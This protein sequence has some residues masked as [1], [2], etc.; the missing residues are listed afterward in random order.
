M[1]LAPC[2][3]VS[4]VYIF[5][6]YIFMLI[7]GGQRALHGCYCCLSG[8][9]YVYYYIVIAWLAH[10]H[11]HGHCMRS[12]AIC[13]Y[14]YGCCQLLLTSCSPRGSFI[15]LAAVLETGREDLRSVCR[16]VFVCLLVPGIYLVRGYTEAW[17]SPPMFIVFVMFGA[18]LLLY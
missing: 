10:R 7:H 3:R 9:L 6:F 14:F 5:I 2:K 4:F 11:A 8:L 17:V 18:L 16:A 12:P 15:V 1:T 13:I